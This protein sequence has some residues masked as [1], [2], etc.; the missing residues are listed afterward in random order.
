MKLTVTPTPLDG[1]LLIDTAYVQD[2]RGFFLES[3]HQ[4]DY[5]AAGLT[6]TFVQDNHSRSEQGV[7]RGLHYQDL[8]AP[9]DKLVRCTLG[10]IFDV[11]VDL[12][13]GSP[14][15]G[16]WTAIELS[17]ENKRQIYIPAGFAHGFQ[18]LSESAEVQ[19]KQTGFYH[20]EAEGTIAWNDPD[21][22]IAWPLGEPTLSARDQRGAS[23]R[24]Y[25]AHPAFRYG[26]TG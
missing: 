22:A 2:A 8:T 5:A 9:L 10:A 11:A 12:R 16:R 20:H 19:Y 13:V 21:L 25:A 7:L 6:R 1:V 14:T 15:F 23:L 4:R 17:Q 24:D 26:P 18:A 3:Y